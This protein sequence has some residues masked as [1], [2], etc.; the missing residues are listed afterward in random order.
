MQLLNDYSLY[1]RIWHLADMF[2]PITTERMP[3]KIIRSHRLNSGNKLMQLIFS[4]EKVSVVKQT[5]TH[6]SYTSYTA[7]T[8]AISVCTDNAIVASKTSSKD[9]GSIKLQLSEEPFS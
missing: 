4:N 8:M 1:N 7:A 6:R 5:H 2:L 3:G 9:V